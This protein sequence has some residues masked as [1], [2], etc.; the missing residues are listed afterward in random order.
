M[1]LPLVA[2]VGAP[3]V[4]KST[5]FNRLVGRRQAIVSNEPGVTRDRID[6]EVRDTS[7][8]FRLVDT[9]GL[10]LSKE[11]LFAREIEQQANVV[12]AE[13]TAILFVVDARAGATALDQELATIFLR[14]GLRPLLVGNKVDSASTR[15][16]VAE[17]HTLGLGE[18][19]EVSA[20]HGTG[21]DDLLEALNERL[22]ETVEVEQQEP[23]LSVAIVGRPHVGKS[24]IFNRLLGEERVLVSERPGTT[25]DAIDTLLNVG[26]RRYRLIDTAGLR[27]PGRIR[28]RVERFSAH[29]ARDNIERCDVAVLV[30]DASESL[31]A[32]DTHIAGAILDAYKPLVVAV[33]KWDLIENR[34]ASVKDWEDRVH[35]RLRFTH[36][37]PL[38]FVSAV[39]GQ[40]L[41]KILERADELHA[42][43]GIRVPTHQLNLWV[44]DHPT[45]QPA[46]GSRRVGFRM[47]YATQTGI[48]PPSFV[49][50][51]NDPNRAHFSVRRQ[52]ANG[53][54]RSF[55][56]GAAPIRLIFRGRHETLD[57]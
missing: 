39:S 42:A 22:P 48:H 6:G 36:G 3:N 30:L 44:Q 9:G 43:S 11:A 12:L 10:S 16:R 49:L 14:R 28:D 8:P 18:P 51:C 26:D 7:R 34:E 4:G 32:Q 21:V 17:L 52:I 2:I 13:A 25:R 45:S 40:R 55:G 1:E 46:A 50:F 56:F 27:R 29:R 54:R 37:A 19:I 35:V 47:L 24:S 41:L 33:N 15:T 57:R 53:L 31:A 38:V 23:R 5:L 20:E